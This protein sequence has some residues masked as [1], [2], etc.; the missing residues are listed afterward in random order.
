[1][2][3]SCCYSPTKSPRTPT[4]AS[5]TRL[6]A[7]A[8]LTLSLLLGGTRSVQAQFD[9][10]NNGNDT[11]PPGPWT[12][13]DPLG[14]L[15]APPA[16]FILTNGAYRIISPMPLAE[17][18]GPARAGSF[19]ANSIYENEFYV[20]ADV[21]DFDDT[22]RQAFGIAAR[23]STPGLGTTSGYLFS[24]EPGSGTLP[25]TNNGD[26]DISTL[27]NEAATGQI[28]TGNSNLHLERGKSYRFVFTG[29]GFD[30]EGRVYE[31]PDTVNPLIRLPAHDDQQLYPNGFTGLI[32]ADQ[33]DAPLNPAD[34]TFDNFLAADHDPGALCDTFGSP[35]D[36][37]PPFTWSHYDPLGELGDP[38]PPASYVVTNGAYRIYAPV[39]PVPDAG[40]ARAGSFVTNATFSDFYVSADLID[41]DDTVRQAFG[42][43]ARAGTP[44][45][46]TTT[47][48]LF[49][50]EPGGGTL[51]GTT[52]GDLDIS[53]LVG[54]VP[55]GQIE[56]GDSQLHLERGKSYRFV[57]MGHG[58]DFEGQVYELPD[59]E[60][61]LIRL[62]AQDPS[63]LVR[64]RLFGFGGRGPG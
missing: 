55:I 42:V 17:D 9:D 37:K 41:F 51:P 64:E 26:L 50:W 58:F 61:P 18:A 14:N 35:D 28:E 5:Q 30:F 52:N 43:M 29:K 11:S 24:W 25:G 44:G 34:A 3:N 10:F 48:Y 62:P 8:L 12:H 6:G 38:F 23:V 46:G 4:T 54:E 40:A 33:G 15:T 32:V 16:S 27:V 7:A 59:V 56:I 57:F 1:M 53:P 60:H 49:S 19:L 13:Y 22:V 47:G 45:L 63:E 36:T 31:L 2:K 20:S 39:P 21:I